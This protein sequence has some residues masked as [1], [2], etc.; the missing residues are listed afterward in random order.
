MVGVVRHLLEMDRDAQVLLTTVLGVLA[1]FAAALP[2][3]IVGEFRKADRRQAG[4]RKQQAGTGASERGRFA[5]P[6]P[7]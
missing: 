6:P 5:P 3:W 1:C 7:Q 4:W 2:A